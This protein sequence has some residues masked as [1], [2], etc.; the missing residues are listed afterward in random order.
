[1]WNIQLDAH[2][3]GDQRKTT[4][5]TRYGH[6]EYVG[7]PFGLTNTPCVFQHLMNNVFREYLDNFVVYYIDDI[8]I[9]PNNMEDEEHHVHLV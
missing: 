7:I 5:R 2:S 3:R 8:L 1:M 6:F 4:F 9:F